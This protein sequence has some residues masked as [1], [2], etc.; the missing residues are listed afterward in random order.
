MGAAILV[1]RFRQSKKGKREEA[2][3]ITG[4]DKP[5]EFHRL[6]PGTLPRVAGDG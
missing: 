5:T 1:T 3:K 4:K 2:I 6:C